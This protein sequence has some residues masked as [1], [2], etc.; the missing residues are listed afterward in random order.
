MKPPTILGWD[1]GGAHIKAVQL[2]QTGHI[3]Q[4][5]HCFAPLW[6]G[7]EQITGTV[8]SIHQPMPSASIHHAITM[9]GELADIFSSRRDG[10]AQIHR[11][12]S[13]TLAPEPLRYFTHAGNFISDPQHQPEQVGSMNWMA[14]A[15]WAA[16]NIEHGVMVDVGSTTTD[17]VPICNHRVTVRGRTDDE[18][19]HTQELVYTGVA[20]TALMS[21]A[22]QVIWQGQ[23]VNLMAEQFATTADVY[24]LLGQLP[25]CLKSFV[26]ADGRGHSA[27]ESAQRL[28]RMVG[29]DSEEGES[30]QPWIELAQQFRAIQCE[31][32]T[33]NLRIQ[34]PVGTLIGA[35]SGRF[36]L[37]EIAARCDLAYQDIDGFLPNVPTSDLAPADCL[38]AYAVADLYRHWHAHH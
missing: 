38:A 34:K 23:A 19:L 12:I 36:L 25:S 14:S 26:T 15:A 28:A 11:S 2:S 1:I 5:W 13:E 24:N 18:R 30:L 32:I 33:E 3:E 8:Q 29:Q 22:P 27:V 9:T 4:I 31:R 16:G 6:K 21:L 7:L 37:P 35:G 20:R 10:V 17:I